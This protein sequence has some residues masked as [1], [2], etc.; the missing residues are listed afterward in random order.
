MLLPRV[1]AGI[2]CLGLPT[3]D[4]I[5]IIRGMINPP[6]DSSHPPVTKMSPLQ[7]SNPRRTSPTECVQP[8]SQ[9]LGTK[10]SVPSTWYQVLGTKY[11]VPSTWYQVLGTKYLV[12]K[13]LSLRP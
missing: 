13:A 12:L 9:V 1:A 7:N 10:Y 2:A 4:G 11:L 5:L 8:P 6:T 3:L